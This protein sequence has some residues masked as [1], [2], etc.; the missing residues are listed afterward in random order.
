MV[1]TSPSTSDGTKDLITQ[2]EDSVHKKDQLVYI[3]EVHQLAKPQDTASTSKPKRAECF[4]E[5]AH[6][7]PDQY[8][9]STMVNR[10]TAFTAI[11][12]WYFTP[13]APISSP[14]SRS[15]PHTL[16]RKALVLFQ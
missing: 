12:D 8:A 13:M 14:H 10:A 2:T 11:Y 6:H 15:L 9:A 1:L 4:T 5:P 16:Q 3:A 7:M